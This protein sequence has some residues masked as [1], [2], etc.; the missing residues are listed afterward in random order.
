MKNLVLLFTAFFISNYTWSQIVINEG[1]NKNYQTIADEDGEYEDWIELYNAGT[2]AVDL[3]GYSLTDNSNEPAQWVFPHYNLNPGEF[4]IVFCS[5]KNRFATT[6]FTTAI[7]SGSFT[8]VVGWNTHIFTTPFQ[9]D[10][11]S[12]IAI[13]VCSYSNTGYITNSSFMQ[14]ATAYGSTTYS[15][16]DGSEGSC[17]YS[18][19]TLAFQR[20]NMKLNGITIGTGTIQ[21]GY[22]DYPAPYGNW[23]WSARNQML[24]PAVEL[25]AAGLSAGTITSLSFQV[26]ANAHVYSLTFYN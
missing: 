3:F 5:D 22:T 15:Y 19:G 9:W 1:S 10:G 4:L 12:S 24:I 2:S 11:L 20:P 16:N 14:T 18:Q 23:Y 25:T 13:N 26:A 7:N 21:N 8:P 6:P 17:S